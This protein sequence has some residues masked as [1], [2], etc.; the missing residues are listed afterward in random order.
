MSLKMPTK[1]QFKKTLQELI[2]DSETRFHKALQE[3][4]P[5]WDDFEVWK[6][7]CQDTIDFIYGPNSRNLNEFN[8]IKYSPIDVSAEPAQ[9]NFMFVVGLLIASQRLKGILSTVDNFL[10]DDAIQPSITH[11]TIFLS[12]SGKSQKMANELKSFLENLGATVIDVMSEPNILRSVDQK[13]ES[14]LNLCNLGIALITADDEL[15]SG[16]KREKPNIDHEIGMMMKA[17]NIAS[18]IVLLKEDKVTK[19]PSNIQSKGYITFNRSAFSKIFSD[20]VKEIRAFGY[21]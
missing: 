17:S 9:Q 2:T 10:P 16:E 8:N 3:G 14:Y 21:Y 19:L 11:P 1:T 13:V 7:R 6:S 15:K 5:F 4:K 20:L 12:H 18:R